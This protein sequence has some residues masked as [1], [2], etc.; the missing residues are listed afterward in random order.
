MKAS[1]DSRDL[2]LTADSADMIHGFDQPRMAAAGDDDESTITLNPH[3]HI[4]FKRIR[5][6]SF[7]IKKKR[8]AC[9][10]K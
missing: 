1:D 6:R 7:Q 9:I 3:S 10:L 4:V 5:T 8:S 2:L